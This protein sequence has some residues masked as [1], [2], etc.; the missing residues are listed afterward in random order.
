MR[1][2]LRLI[3][4]LM[5]LI[6]LPSLV[7]ESQGVTVNVKRHAARS[8]VTSKRGAQNVSMK[9]FHASDTGSRGTGVRVISNNKFSRIWV[10]LKSGT[11]LR[12]ALRV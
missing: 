5:H 6:S 12:L 2:N 10:L 3:N 4:P 9:V 7:T 11:A 1:V 8:G